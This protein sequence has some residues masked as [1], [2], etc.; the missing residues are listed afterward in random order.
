[1]KTLSTF[2]LAV[3]STSA[4]FAQAP[5]PAKPEPTEIEQLRT[6][7]DELE[8]RQRDS[9]IRSTE[10]RGTV[11]TYLGESVAFGGFFES[12]ISGIK[13]EHTDTQFSANSH[14][15]GLNIAADFSERLRFTSQLLTGLTFTLSNP[16]NNP[17]VSVNQREFTTPVYGALPAQSYIEYTKSELAII[18]V[19][20][21]YVPFGRAY[22]QREVVLF[23]R[24]GGP[25]MIA[26]N[27][28][29]SIGIANPLWM[30]VHVLGSK[31]TPR[32]RTGYDLYTHTPFT[33]ATTVGL[34][35]RAWMAHG[36]WLTYG[37]S[38]QSGTV[39]QGSYLAN[40]V[41]AVIKLKDFSVVGEAAV[42]RDSNNDTVAHSFYVE[43]GFSFK[44]DEYLVFAAADYLD[45]AMATTGVIPD[46]Y[47]KWVYGGGINWIPLPVTRYRLSLLHHDYVG[48]TAVLSGR[49]RDYLL[50]DLSAG[51]AF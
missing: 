39:K 23:Q 45:N 20:L 2:I 35:G 42:T 34:G 28:G 17:A 16:H 38:I 51:I 33:R 1:M 18:Q 48:D 47:R 11:K 44:E 5:N 3:L 41:D 37:Y 6:R 13:G 24:R 14:V 49:N 19:G 26:S 46:Q 27:S 25:Q 4:S 7:L 21:G 10:S 40:G 9:Y 30:G 31:A 8:K 29:T 43:P 15:L 36:E 22:Q 12:G 32:G 50:L